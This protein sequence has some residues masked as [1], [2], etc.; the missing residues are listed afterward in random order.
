MSDPIAV[1]ILVAEA[2]EHCGLRYVVGGSLASS[3]SGEPP[4]TLDVDIVVSM[5]A[6]HIVADS[7]ARV[8][9]ESSRAT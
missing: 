9:P 1:A 2:L 4:S 5:D 6:E 3:I 7:I 8:S